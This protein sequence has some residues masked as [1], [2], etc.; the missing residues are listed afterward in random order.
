M[1]AVFLNWDLGAQCW[2]V[3]GDPY[4]CKSLKWLD[5]RRQHYLPAEKLDL[6]TMQSI[7]TYG[8]GC[9]STVLPMTQLIA[10]QGFPL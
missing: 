5:F 4:V 1:S 10:I 7:T 2:L 3:P 8:T 6:I 9:L